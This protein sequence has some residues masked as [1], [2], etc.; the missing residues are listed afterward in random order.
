MTFVVFDLDD[1]LYLERDFV[2]SGYRAVGIYARDQ[3]GIENLEPAC[4][5]VFASG[6]RRRVFDK[7]LLSLGAMP[8]RDLVQD[9]V[10]IYREHT[11]AIA[12]QADADRALRRFSGRCALI[13]DGPA[14]TQAAKVAALG[15]NE[16]LSPIV[17]TGTLGI[18]AGKPAPLAFEMLADATG[19]SGADLVYVAD[20]PV[21]DFV[22]PR[23]MGWQTVM[24]A[25]KMR[26]HLSP[27][28]TT[29]HAAAHRITSLDMLDDCLT[30][31]P[32][33]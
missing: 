15:L 1:T 23:R 24:I 3:H 22:S 14:K 30:R 21:K 5:T 12:L 32:K 18:G 31:D 16:R 28:P 7:A 8:E 27:P 25:R 13:S 20:N 6:E 19:L 4:R 29:D 10:R 9:L 26:V 33:D 17:L 2:L 11:P